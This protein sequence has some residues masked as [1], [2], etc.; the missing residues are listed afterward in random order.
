M[1]KLFITALLGFITAGSAP[2]WC[3]MLF[4][5]CPAVEDKTSLQSIVVTVQSII[6]EIKINIGSNNTNKS[7]QNNTYN[8]NNDYSDN[9]NIPSSPNISSSRELS[10]SKCIVMKD[11]YEK[12]PGFYNFVPALM[13]E[14]DC[15]RWRITVR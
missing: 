2:W 14:G 9:P 6:K 10:E 13:R 7:T 12:N 4:S 5:S 15:A 3:S 1:K 8:Q 11:M